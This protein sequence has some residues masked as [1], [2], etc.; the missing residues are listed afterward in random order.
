MPAK[1]ELVMRQTRVLLRLAHECH[2]PIQ[3][4]FLDLNGRVMR[5]LGV[6][7]KELF[8]TIERL[9]LRPLPAEAYEFARQPRL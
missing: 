2:H 4:V 1:R 9:A 7:R 3:A 5:Q 8:E 6:S